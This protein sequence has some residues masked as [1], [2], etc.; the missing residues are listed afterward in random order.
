[1]IS[2]KTFLENIN[3][4]NRESALYFYFPWN[5]ITTINITY[6]KKMSVLSNNMRINKSSRYIG[7]K[8]N[9]FNDAEN[10]RI[11]INRIFDVKNQIIPLSGFDFLK[12]LSTDIKKYDDSKFELKKL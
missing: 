11:Q 2:D 8:M 12:V 4:S 7:Y 6:P 1:M 3:L 5:E 9:I 10:N